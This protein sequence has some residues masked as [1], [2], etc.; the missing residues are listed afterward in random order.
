MSA[1]RRTVP[2]TDVALA[3]A[4]VAVSALFLGKLAFATSDVYASPLGGKVVAC[5]GALAKIV[6]LWTGAVLALRATRAFEKGSHSRR[7]FAL[8]TSWLTLWATAQSILGCYQMF[9]GQ[10]APFPSAADPFFVAG[11]P[12]MLAAFVLLIV[13]YA[14][15][16]LL[17]PSRAHVIVS[18]AAALPF[19]VLAFFVLRPVVAAGG[20]PAELALNLAYPAFDVVALVPVVV[21]VRIALALRGGALFWVFASLTAGIVCLVGGDLLYAWFSALEYQAL[22]P[23][24]DLL[25]LYGYALI[26]RAVALQHRIT[27]TA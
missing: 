27:S 12:L 26:A 18:L 13:A 2:G 9:L 10:A 21:L 1:E 5:V 20:P 7:A 15:T 4:A 22:D 16:G 19:A 3:V 14:S 8:V 6:S 23:V 11:Y 24:L 17:G 25:F